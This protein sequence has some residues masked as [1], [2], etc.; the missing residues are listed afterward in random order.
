MVPG[1]YRGVAVTSVEDE[2][3]E[4][5]LSRHFVGLDAYRRTRFLVVRR[6][7]RTAIG[8]VQ[9]RSEEPLFSPIAEFRLLAD[10]DECV[11]LERPDVDTAVPS[12]L[13]QVA[14]TEAPGAR[15]VV[16]LGRYGHVSFIVDPAPLR[17]AVREV[18][19]PHPAKLLDQTQRVLEVAEHL[20]P[21]ELVPDLVDLE[22]LAGETPGGTSSC[23]AGAAA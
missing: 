11:F 17:V 18:V 4:G 10:A 3:D 2:L 13:A 8:A 7:S 23:R 12:A 9:K 20:P 6:G 22:R 14:R 16:V 21:I 15:G 19:P 5:S 1:A